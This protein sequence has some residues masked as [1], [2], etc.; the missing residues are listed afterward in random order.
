MSV[1]A[2]TG[3]VL[4]DSLK[5]GLRV[6]FVGTAAGR[7]SAA[8]GAY[9]AHRGNRFWRTLHEIRL[10]SREYEPGEFPRLLDDGIG[11]TDVAKGSAGMDHQVPPASFDVPA[12]LAKIAKFRPGVVAF[13]SKRAASVWLSRSTGK[14]CV[15]PQRTSMPG[16]AIAFV[17][18]SPSGAAARYWSIA[19]W[20]E[21]AA[22]VAPHR[23]DGASGREAHLGG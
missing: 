10:T 18:P 5:A 4:P 15:G 22:L 3:D 20:H 14:I 8:V 9:Y 1:T 16:G 7:R 23:I 2:N 6:V 21:L 12:F 19:P 11:F 13:T 17:L